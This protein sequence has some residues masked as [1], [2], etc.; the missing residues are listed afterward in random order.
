MNWRKYTVYFIGFMILSIA[1]Y[2]VVAIS[3]GGTEA[4]ISHV[5]IEWSYKH[6]VFTFMFGFVSGHLFWRVRQTKKLNDLG[7]VV[8]EKNNNDIS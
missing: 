6:P 4:S 1:I 2:D 5:M 7:A 3:Q 8:V